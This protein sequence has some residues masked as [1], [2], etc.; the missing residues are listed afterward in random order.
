MQR[1][2]GE[3][4]LEGVLC[5]SANDSASPPVGER[6]SFFR[7]LVSGIALLFPKDAVPL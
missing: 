6:H 2:R 5:T 7:L 3:S 4:T 1:P